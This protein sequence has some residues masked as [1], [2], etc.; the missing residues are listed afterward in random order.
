M[1]K[2][3]SR[4]ILPPYKSWV[5]KFFILSLIH[6]KKNPEIEQ[7]LLLSKT[8][9]TTYPC[10]QSTFSSAPNTQSVF[11]LVETIELFARK[12]FMFQEQNKNHVFQHNSIRCTL[13]GYSHR[14]CIIFIHW[15][16][17]SM[18]IATTNTCSTEPLN[19]T[20]GGWW[21]LVRS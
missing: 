13:D 6:T 3:S 17:T 12:I 18:R 11:I 10:S 15:N 1:Q 2:S 19:I 7:K 14:I 8:P 4:L 5:T 9:T 20:R 16:K 21:N